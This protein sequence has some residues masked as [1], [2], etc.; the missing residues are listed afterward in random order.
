MKAAGSDPNGARTH[1]AKQSSRESPAH[2]PMGSSHLA[3]AGIQPH[4][5]GPPASQTVPVGVTS[6]RHAPHV[7]SIRAGQG[8]ADPQTPVMKPYG[9]AT[10][11]RSQQNN[12]GDY[13]PTH[14]GAKVQTSM[15]PPAAQY[16]THN[17]SHQTSAP[18]VEQQPAT[19]T[20]THQDPSNGQ[21]STGFLHPVQ[22]AIRSVEGILRPSSRVTHR[23]ATAPPAAN[24]GFATAHA[25]QSHV[26]SVVHQLQSQ[27]QIQNGGTD[28]R[29]RPHRSAS[30]GNPG[31]SQVYGA[32]SQS[33]PAVARATA[34]YSP[35]PAHNPNADMFRSPGL[36]TSTQLEGTPAD[37]PQ[38]SYGASTG[39]L[40]RKASASNLNATGIKQSSATP[41]AD[42]QAIAQPTISVQYT[43]STYPSANGISYDP[44]S[45][46]PPS[47]LP[48]A[49]TVAEATFVPPS[50]VPSADPHYKELSSQRQ[51]VV[52]ESVSSPVRQVH[53]KLA[54]T[55][56]HHLSADINAAVHSP[57]RN[58]HTMSR[59]PGMSTIMPPNSTPRQHSSARLHSHRNGSTDTITLS[60]APRPSQTVQSTQP[61]PLTNRS[62]ATNLRATTSRP[63]T[64]P[65]V[66]TANASSGYPEPARYRSPAPSQ[67]PQQAAASIPLV[68][69]STSSLPNQAQIYGNHAPSSRPALYSGGPSSTA[70]EP[71]HSAYRGAD[72]PAGYSAQT[73]AYL[74][75]AGSSST[76]APGGQRGPPRTAASPAPTVNARQYNGVSTPSSQQTVLPPSH[77]QQARNN[78]YTNSSGR[79]PEPSPVPDPSHSHARA[80]SDPHHGVST[81]RVGSHSAHMKSRSDT[82]P[83]EAI[84]PEVLLTPSSL[85]PTL[86]RQLSTTSTVAPGTARGSRDKTVEREPR[87]KG[88][89]FSLFR[90]RS[91]PPREPEVRPP[92]A[93]HQA[94]LRKESA[95]PNPGVYSVNQTGTPQASSAH[96]P[97]A[98]PSS[99]YPSHPSSANPSTTHPPNPSTSHSLSANPS[100]APMSSNTMQQDEEARRL[101]RRA[102]NAEAAV[103]NGRRNGPPDA[104]STNAPATGRKSP[105]SK[106]FT[107]FR[108]LSKRHRTV[109][110]ASVE[111]VD[112]TVANTVIT[113]ASSTRSSTAGRLS[114]PLRDPVIAAQEWRNRE[115]ADQ[116]YR[117]T[118]RRRRPGVTFEV[119]DGRSEASQALQR[120]PR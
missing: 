85:A 103:P 29:T 15:D 72:V 2:R 109:S 106:M 105:G 47:I 110:V 60:P 39:S 108:L 118:L 119:E 84:E 86:P 116:M 12:V 77:P 76:V 21:A 40:R 74:A 48:Q 115:E 63:E 51:N 120:D 43:T 88:G 10:V 33:N 98:H 62:S 112:G 49:V 101:R 42:R 20:A 69:S 38:A 23:S 3:S 96:A 14:E 11:N 61:Q 5:P 26:G 92:A 37:V 117:G 59:S 83:G 46:K 99:A 31:M 97:S 107:P 24:Q 17:A 52:L 41:Y 94:R 8:P 54:P 114:P 22:Q 58:P 35:S 65:T 50:R 71:S 67:Y 93:V 36:A 44:R 75:S 45:P 32:V 78:T 79:R 81:S 30:Q 57:Y 27:S 70:P 9:T 34:P 95:P 68:S 66:R 16:G 7:V 104:L 73:S 1:H 82:R 113:G 4:T 102:Q 53:S 55:A 87:K 56:A 91:S 25:V 80:A 18:V 6:Q 100:S 111:A 89:F 13:V 64:N 90:S 28:D 19:R